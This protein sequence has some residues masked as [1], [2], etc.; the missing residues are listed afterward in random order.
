MDGLD[1]LLDLISDDTS[2]SQPTYIL[3]GSGFGWFYN[4]GNKQMVR[5]RRGIECILFDED[6]LDKNKF[7]V[8]IDN[9]ILS[10]S[11]EEILE[12]GWN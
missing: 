4:G 10:I 2:I 7:I 11:K 5:V 3:S 6:P 12:V 1:S 8:E 9:Q